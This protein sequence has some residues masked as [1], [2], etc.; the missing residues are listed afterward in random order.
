M[1]VLQSLD[2]VKNKSKRMIHF[3]VV[4]SSSSRAVIH[5][6]VSVVVFHNAT[7]NAKFLPSPVNVAIASSQ[8][9]AVC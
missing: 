4:V 5:G 2:V 3:F 8:A 7:E 1:T 9:V 6:L